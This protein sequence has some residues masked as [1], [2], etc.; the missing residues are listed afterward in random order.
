MA[1]RDA[2]DELEGLYRAMDY[3][4]QLVRELDVALN[5]EAGSAKQAS[6]CDLVSQVKAEQ[7]RSKNFR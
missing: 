5:G 4:R 2:A 7:I 1:A 3:H 6:L